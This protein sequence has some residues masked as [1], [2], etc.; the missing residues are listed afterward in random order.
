MTEQVPDDIDEIK[1]RNKK[2]KNRANLGIAL[3]FLCFLIQ[4]IVLIIEQSCI[5]LF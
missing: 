1:I 3:I 4:L 2:I 5:K